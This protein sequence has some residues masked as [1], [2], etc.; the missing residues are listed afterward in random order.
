MITLSDWDKH[1]QG[2]KPLFYG[3]NGKVIDLPKQI[4]IAFDKTLMCWILCLNSYSVTFNEIFKTRRDCA[5]WMIREIEKEY[6]DE[7]HSS[8]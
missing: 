7:K 5:E 4:P 8:L 6:I 2:G 1:C 3:L